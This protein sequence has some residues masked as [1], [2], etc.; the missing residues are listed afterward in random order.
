MDPLQFLANRLDVDVKVDVLVEHAALV[1]RTGRP[2]ALT[3]SSRAERW[4]RLPAAA[5]LLHVARLEWPGRYFPLF[6]PDDHGDWQAREAA[7]MQRRDYRRP[8]RLGLQTLMPD[9][10]L[11]RWRRE[12]V[13]LA[14]A[15]E[16]AGVSE[17]DVEWRV[18]TWEI[19]QANATRRQVSDLNGL[20]ERGLLRRAADLPA[21]EKVV[22]FR[23]LE[24]RPTTNPSVLVQRAWEAQEAGR[25]TDDDGDS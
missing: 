21:V 20:F 6:V 17:A 13:S 5:T 4:E 19:E 9:E 3:V 14:E 8:F 7:M 12:Q 16:E 18:R 1:H 23:K 11:A 25:A 24:R 10:M 15:A 2:S 22:R